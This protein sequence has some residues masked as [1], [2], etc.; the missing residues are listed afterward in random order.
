MNAEAQD[1]ANGNSRCNANFAT[2]TDGGNPRMQMFLCN[3]TNPQRDGDFDNGVIVHEY[4]HGI[5]IRQVG[6]PGNSSCLNNRQQP[7]EG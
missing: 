3:N 2:P 7:G 4:G 5:S 1:N 6:G